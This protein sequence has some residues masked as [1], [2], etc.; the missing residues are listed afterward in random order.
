MFS[1]ISKNVDWVLVAAL[2]PILAAGVVTM[3]SHGGE[4]SY[5]FKQSLW[6]GVAFGVFFLLSTVDAQVFKKAGTLVWLFTFGISLLL[7]VFLLGHTAK[8]A[9]SW[10]NF[11][12][13]SL[14][15]ADPMKLVLILVFSKYLS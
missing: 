15:P 6:I 14:Q 12:G 5:V 7:V 10:L 13:F 2:V 8:G 3:S 1:R 9:T 11:G 4:S